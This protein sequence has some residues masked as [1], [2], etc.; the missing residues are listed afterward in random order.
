MTAA[1]P[2]PLSRTLRGQMPVLDAIRGVAIVLVLAHRFNLNEDPDG[3]PARLVAATMELGWVGVQLFFVLSGFLITGILLDTARSEHY[4]RAFFGRRVLR[5]FPLYYAVLLLVLVLVPLVTGS[6]PE[7]HQ[8]QLWLWVYLSNWVAPLGL[9]VT[10]LGHFWSLAVEEQFYLTW[11]FLVRWLAGRR[12]AVL[13]G[14]L[15]V[16]APASRVLLRALGV[17]PEPVY[18]FTVCR[19]DALAMGSAAA[20]ALRVPE[21]ALALERRQRWLAGSAVLLLLA[22]AVA[23]RGYPR[24]SLLTQ[25][26][27]YSRLA[28]V[29]LV[30]V[31]LGVLAEAA[32]VKVA[33]AALRTLGK[34]SYAMYVFHALLHHAVGV[35]L[36]AWLRPGTGVAASLGYFAVMTGLTFGVALLSY[37]LLEKHFLALKRRF[38]A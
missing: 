9:G 14:L 5:I 3:L 18:E 35:P 36:L 15:V 26:L 2:T 22:G 20:W 32:G 16:V 10:V 4:Y 19:I 13:C 31:V 23:T 21:V 24:T 30:A 8:H 27:G 34:Y 11:P 12:L 17:G 7:G 33:P 25:T 6:Q 28:G 38:T 1:P 29:A 37:H